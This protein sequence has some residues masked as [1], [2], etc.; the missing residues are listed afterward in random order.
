[1]KH[2]IKTL[3]DIQH[4]PTPRATWPGQ[5]WSRVITCPVLISTDPRAAP[6]SCRSQ[7]P[8]SSDNEVQQG[9]QWGMGEHCV[10]LGVWRKQSG[11]DFPK[12]LPSFHDVSKLDDSIE[13]IHFLSHINVMQNIPPR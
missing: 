3:H 7:H 13:F 2:V 9:G 10:H 12:I 1:M 4:H 5:Q 11:V 8:A 6:P